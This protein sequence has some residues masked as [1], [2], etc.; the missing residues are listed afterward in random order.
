LGGRIAAIF[1]FII[2]SSITLSF[3]IH[4]K[5]F[6]PLLLNTYTELN[7]QKPKTNSN[8]LIFQQ[9]K[10]MSSTP[11][12]S[13]LLVMLLLGM[14]SLLV[15]GIGSMYVCVIEEGCL[16]QKECLLLPLPK[17]LFALEIGWH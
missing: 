3:I 10:T 7:S 6:I 9:K 17:L 13:T 12:L 5:I 15:L 1:K 8:I 4:K 2:W 16:F 11:F 14:P